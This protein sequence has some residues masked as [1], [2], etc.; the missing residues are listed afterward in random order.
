MNAKALQ[1]VDRWFGV[2]LC[3]ALTLVR[4]IIGLFPRFNDSTVQ[5]PPRRVLIVKLAEQGSTVLA[6]PALRRAVETFGRENVFFIAFED[7]R[8]ILDVLGVIPKENVVTVS[9]CS[10]SG[11]LQSTLVAI[12]RLRRMKLAAAV[13]M[14]FFSR[15]SAALAF[16]SGA[17]QRVGFHAFFGA[18]P[19]RGDLMTHRLLY[20]P[21]L[22]TSETF[23]TLIEALNCD[24]AALPTFAFAATESPATPPLF[25]PEPDEI[26]DVEKML[27]SKF[28]AS[29]LD[30]Q[31]SEPAL[32]DVHPEA[33]RLKADGII[34][35]NPNA[36]D[37]LPLRRWPGERY[38]DLARR[39]LKEFPECI[40]AFTG[41]P[42]E[43]GATGK[44]A[45]EVASDRCISLAGKTTLKQLLVLYTLADVLVTNDSG[46][47]HF[48]TLTPIEIV[49]L[50]G[51]ETP[52]L[53]AARTPRNTVLYAGLACSPCVSAY[54]NRVSPCR[55]NLCMQAI[56]T[57]QVFAAVC[58]AYA[59]RVRKQTALAVC[60]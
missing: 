18:G 11:F 28:R 31:V 3:R 35:L 59:K 22:H 47:A 16:L 8:F 15:G 14:E 49:T 51:P 1:R 34:L 53:F 43:A 55:N 26:V 23:L 56:S 57:D 58:R 5:R 2:P 52:E 46:P 4:G 40:I 17:K 6:Y 29:G 41:A 27:F 60:S 20:N 25:A 50:F 37:L 54:N 21:H 39:L 32:F 42:N 12:R 36:S 9:V 7:N 48:A 44:L 33:Q 30:F 13:D 45:R 19:Y 10:V 24:P 38:A